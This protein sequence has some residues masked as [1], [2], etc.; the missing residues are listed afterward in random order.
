MTDMPNTP[1]AA[2]F[3]DEIGVAFGATMME[4]L[5]LAVIR[6]NPTLDAKT[7]QQRLNAAM[8]ALLGQ[9]VTP[10]AMPGDRDDRALLFMAR[11]RHCDM[12][13]HDLYRITRRLKPGKVIS[14]PPKPRSDRALAEL[15]TDRFFGVADEGA[16]IAVVNRLRE[17]FS[18]SYQ[19]K[20]GKGHGVN[21]TATYIYRAVEHDYVQE[22]LEAE[23]LKRGSGLIART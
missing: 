12:A 17:K 20:Q 7:D 14:E 18:G 9:K 1:D 4:R 3:D 21:H 22:S 8:T 6:A 19:R 15:A 5:M 2:S 11:E 10:N 13:E 16:R 23:A